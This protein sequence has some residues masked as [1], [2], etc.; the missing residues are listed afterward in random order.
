LEIRFLGAHN[1]EAK[2]TKCACL[3]IDNTLAVDAGSITSSLDIS[4]QEKLDAIL[5][6]HHHYD[7][8]RDIPSIALN[9]SHRGN[10]IDVYATSGV[11]NV[12]E[13]H[14]LN[15]ILYPKYYEV[16]EAK[17]TVNFKLITPYELQRVD[18]HQIQAIPVNHGTDTMGFN[19]YGTEGKSVFYTADTG[20]DLAKCWQHVSP[21]LI[22]ADITMPNRYEAFARKTEHLTPGLLSQEL[23]TFR[24]MKGY[25]PQVIVMHMDVTLEAEIEKE[26]TAIAA[27]LGASITLAHE[28]MQLYI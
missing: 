14:L 7:H 1:S 17:P 24:R 10:N 2:T 3:L 15:G 12:I 26:I 9:L 18:G 16:P 11:R 23:I 25:L 20:P 8:I 22:I 21:Q 27:E 28:G 19:I 13:T 4:D 6:S 5:L